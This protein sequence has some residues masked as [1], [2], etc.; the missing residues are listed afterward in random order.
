MLE[1]KINLKINIADVEILDGEA[2]ISPGQACVF[3]SKD[4]YGDKLL[5]GGWIYK[6]ENKNLST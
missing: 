5:G 6:T 4:N 3:Y 1:A 2:G